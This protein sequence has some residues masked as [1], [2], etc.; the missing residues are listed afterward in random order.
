MV[1]K[2]K[3]LQA[4]V[5]PDLLV[6]SA[7]RG[8]YSE[9]S[10]AE[11]YS[12]NSGT[13]QDKY[14][15]GVIGSGHLSVL[16]HAVFTFSIDGISRA[17]SHQLVRHRV[18]SYSQQSQ[19][20]VLF[21]NVDELDYDKL[22]EQF[23]VPPNIAKKEN[24]KKFYLDACYAALKNY[25]TMV[26]SLNSEDAITAEQAQEDA[27]MLLPNAAK[28]KLTVTMNARELQHFFA[29]R[30]C[31]RA[32]WEIRELA[33]EMFHLV[34]EVAPNIFKQAGPGCLTDGCKE[35][36]HACGEPYN[37]VPNWSSYAK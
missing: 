1:V 37:D 20:Y 21:P 5:N 17:C 28:T 25:Y 3:L 2:V 6:S 18:A 32:Q 16:E 14:L 26:Q 9:K 10:S 15:A 35:G 24:R 30:C 33:W 29:L 27:R 7:A 12:K 34:T 13:P 31:K 4:T 36:K 19:R 23:V 8:C 11:L 22:E